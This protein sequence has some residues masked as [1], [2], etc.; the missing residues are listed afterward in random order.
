MTQEVDFEK[1]K[2]STT[3]IW[4]LVA[5]VVVLCLCLVVVAAAVGAYFYLKPAAG[6]SGPGAS[7][8]P[9]PAGPTHTGAPPPSEVTVEPLDPNNIPLGV[10][11]IYDLVP[12]YQ[13]QTEPGENTYQT[14]IAYDQPVAIFAGWCTIDQDTLDQNFA[15]TTFLLEID[16]SDVPTSGLYWEDGPGNNGVCRTF[17]GVV[18]AWP[19][20]SHTV[21][22]TMRFDQDINDGWGDYTAGDYVD[23]FDITVTP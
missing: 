19:V 17:Y 20:G 21:V 14:S 1:N 2:Q 22:V 11:G 7:P 3:W 12:S 10:Y 18:P 13:G 8:T 23:R 4:V 15:H 16:G 6:V 9:I 5:A